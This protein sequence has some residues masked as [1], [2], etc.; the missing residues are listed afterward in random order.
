M[1]KN[2]NYA[3]AQAYLAHFREKG[4]QPDIVD[5]TE[6]LFNLCWLCV[7]TIDQLKLELEKKEVNIV[8]LR[9]MISGMNGASHSSASDGSNTDH[10]T[11]TESEC[12]SKQEN[13]KTAEESSFS[14]KNDSATED[15]DQ[16]PK[17]KGHG[18]RGVDEYPGAEIVACSHEAYKEGD[19]CPQCALGQLQLKPPK[20]IIQIDGNSPLT[21]RRYE[22]EMLACTMCLFVTTAKAPVDLTSKYTEKAKATLAYLHYFM[23]LPYYRL[24]KMQAMFGVPIA[25]STQSEL[26]PSMMGPIH[27][28]FNYIVIY[29]AQCDL[30][31]QDDTGVKIQ[32]LIKENKEGNPDRRGMFTSGFIA[33]GEYKVVLYFSGRSHAGENFDNIISH[34]EPDK[35]KVNR[36]AD[37]LSANSK[38]EALANESKCAAHAFRRFRSLLSTYPEAALFVLGIYG[39]VYDNDE[40]CKVQQMTDLER[41]DYHQTHSKPLMEKLEQ[42]VNQVL[43]EDEVEPNSVLAAECQYLSNHWMGLTQFLRIAGAPLDNNALETILKYMITYRKNSQTFKTVYSAEYGSRLISIIVTCVVNGIDAI[44]YLTQLQIHESEVWKN[45]QAWL[46]WQYRKTLDQ[47]SFPQT[48]AA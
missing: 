26:M 6:G 4:C 2:I 15:S 36:M 21:G 19:T 14:N 8:R 47:R 40:V 18:R 44:D 12:E 3:D 27:G 46:P 42:W 31:Y 1:K 28:I 39:K 48:Q 9:E 25:A 41:L 11:E 5:N 38:H 23:G 16:K 17:A 10:K 45:P 35:G 30:L 32:S 22:L 24:A 43:S 34:R 33:E 20:T 37:A 13:E 7:E 29:A